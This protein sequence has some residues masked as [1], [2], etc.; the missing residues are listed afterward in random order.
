MLQDRSMRWCRCNLFQWLSTI[1]QEATD[2]GL[3]CGGEGSFNDTLLY[4][5]DATHS[6]HFPGPPLCAAD[7]KII[8][9]C[10]PQL[11]AGWTAITRHTTT[12]TLMEVEIML[13]IRMTFRSVLVLVTC[14]TSLS[15]SRTSSR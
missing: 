8:P 12:I 15:T 13:V 1:Q 4:S 7:G 6:L 9:P 11:Q 5:H 14:S 10:I 2:G 3:L